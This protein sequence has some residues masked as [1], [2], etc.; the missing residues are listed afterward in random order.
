M[1]K[2][3]SQA[4]RP[5]L[6]HSN[7]VAAKQPDGKLL[8]THKFDAPKEQVLWEPIYCAG[9]DVD[10]KGEKHFHHIDRID[11]HCYP[12]PHMWGLW[13]AQREVALWG[14]RG[15][16][17]SEDT[18]GFLVK[19]NYPRYV[20]PQKLEG[21]DITYL[22]CS[23]YAALV[24][25]K[26]AK[27][28]RNYFERA[29]RFFAMYGGEPTLEPMGIRFPSGAYMIFDHMADGDAWEKYQGP[30]WTRIVIE[31]APQ[32]AEEV[33][34]LKLIAACRTSNPNMRAQIML[35]AN[36]GGAGW[37]WF[38]ARF[39]YPEG[40]R[41]KSNTVYK[42]PYSGRT[43]IA[44]FSTVDD[45]PYQMVKQ[46]D[47]D[48]D[49]YRASHSTLYK[50]WR[51]GDPDAVSGQ[52]FETFREHRQES[53]PENAC[54]VVAPR[55]VEKHWPRAIG[56]D[57]GYSHPSAVMWGAWH[58]NGQLHIYRELVASRMGAVVLG[59]EIAKKSLEELQTMRNPHITLYL[60]HD[61]FARTN[62]AA[63][64]AEQIAQGIG[65]I[66]GPD[67]AFV[68]SA[69]EEEELLEDE[70]AWASVKRR[71]VERARKTHITLVNAGLKRRGN[72]NRIREYLRWVPIERDGMQWNDE[73]AARIL[74][75]EGALAYHDYKK[76]CTNANTEIL[77]KLQIH[78]VCPKL[79]GAMQ[80]AQE[81][82]NDP[83]QMQKQDGDDPVDALAYLVGNFAFSEG[84]LSRDEQIAEKLTTVRERYP[85]LST[86]TLVMMARSQEADWARKQAGHAYML[87]RRR[88]RLARVN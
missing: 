20:N 42:E 74:L 85:G 15:S 16:G 32:I 79:I 11:C 48:L 69:N 29:K 88:D 52:F 25:R 76:R 57:W 27:D 13:A 50:Q 51:H 58:P 84:E 3:K 73:V 43:R 4:P 55:R 9:F 80:A 61:A 77:P 2:A 72:L 59:T 71:Q 64:E 26:N 36:P 68:L 35:T 82:E 5:Q 66:L 8:W 24:I 75:T 47:K 38:K 10:E 86:Q 56:C 19:G 60:S 12:G 22:N 83:E 45:N 6:R 18:F 63:T 21:A 33:N 23:D 39:I 81:A 30:E 78:N 28:L 37:A 41:L 7:I 1:A 46:Y 53:E 44:I 49:L 54:H 14:G 70:A 34:Y 67:A 62:D 40:K 17:K 31:E 87:P 65:L